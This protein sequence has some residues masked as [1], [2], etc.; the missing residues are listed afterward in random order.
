[1]ADKKISALTG[2]TTPL[3]GTEVLPI[4]QGGATVKVS[5][6]DLTA[7]RAVSASS[8]TVSQPI[9]TTYTGTYAISS[10]SAATG[11]TAINFYNTGANLIL[12]VEGSAGSSLLTASTPYA[13]IIASYANKP[14]QFGINDGIKATITT[15]GNYTPNVAATGI[16]FTANTPAAGMTS[17]LLNWYEEGTWTPTV[18]STVGTLSGVT[19]TGTYTRIGRQV[20]VAYNILISANGTGAT[21]IKAA[22]L[23]FTIANNRPYG[24]GAETDA[25]GFNITSQ[26]IVSTDYA[27]LTNFAGLYPGGTGYRLQGNFTYT[28]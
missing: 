27:I 15:A 24:V 20:Y 6:A 2:A 28:V 13:V 21:A 17:Q 16:N 8:L 11:P 5:V 19:A 25:V 14:I 12:G 26:G 9:T 23:P 3:A 10:T 18:T 4:V 7:G 1:M 22:G